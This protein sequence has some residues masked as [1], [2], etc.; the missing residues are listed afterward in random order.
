MPRTTDVHNPP[1]D[2]TVLLKRADIALA[3]PDV[4]HF[5][6]LNFFCRA[7]ALSP[8][9][10]LYL[11]F[12]GDAPSRKGLTTVH[13]LTPPLQLAR[14][15]DHRAK[16]RHCADQLQFSSVERRRPVPPKR[17]P[18]FTP[19]FERRK[20]LLICLLRMLRVELNK[21]SRTLLIDHQPFRQPDSRD[22][23]LINIFFP[24]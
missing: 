1:F 15:Q 5:S 3:F 22:P 8:P 24:C 17:H 11:P 21:Q 12:R 10:P 6:I 2:T 20:S 13:V 23:R 4:V 18:A 9:P 19:C 16:P 7:Y 14:F